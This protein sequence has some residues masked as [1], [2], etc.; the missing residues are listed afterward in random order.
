MGNLRQRT[1]ARLH[2]SRRLA[3]ASALVGALAFAGFAL[4]AALGSTTTS[5]TATGP[6]PRTI[7]ANW[8]DTLA[9]VNADSVP[10]GITSSRQELNVATIAPGATYSTIL[11]GR[12][13]TYGYA[14]VEP[15]RGRNARLPGDVVSQVVGTV[16]LKTSRARVTFGK[17]ITLSGTATLS[18][19]VLERR[20][21]GEQG[22][23][24]LQTLTP[25]ADGTYS[26]TVTP[27]LN[28]SFRA[29]IANGQLK[30]TFS[31][32]D[33]APALKI[34]SPAKKTKASRR[35]TITSRITPGN[36][37]KRILLL[38]CNT[39]RGGWTRVAARKP[40]PGGG[41]SFKWP[42]EAGTNYLKTT[43][44]RSDLTRAF[45]P[46]TSAPIKIRAIAPKAKP[47]KHPKPAKPAKPSKGCAAT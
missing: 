1:G 43:V 8:G 34:A 31:N 33:V 37:A 27:T 17:P 4:A 2:G 18:P 26:L 19:V 24:P 9:F 32:V 21:R 11:T 7:T 6:S 14:D 39:K 5:L 29:A 25:A 16:T 40:G 42:A 3:A 12:T 22:F 47:S 36:S 45:A 35:V 41:V 15:S 28:A 10:H 38:Q 30:S 23:K 44:L 13:K 46:P 20:L